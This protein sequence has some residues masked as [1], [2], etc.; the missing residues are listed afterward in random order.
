MLFHLIPPFEFSANSLE[1]KQILP[2]HN[3]RRRK[4]DPSNEKSTSELDLNYELQYMGVKTNKN[5]MH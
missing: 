2:T 5:T 3:V 4:V 1:K